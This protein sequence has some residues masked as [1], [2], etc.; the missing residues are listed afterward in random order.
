VTKTLTWTF[1]PQ[2]K[3]SIETDEGI[4]IH[5]EGKTISDY[6]DTIE[7]SRDAIHIIPYLATVDMYFR[8]L[9]LRY[10]NVR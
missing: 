3:V 2:D 9:G 7:G 6:I 8:K 4:I 10:R 5:G 1:G